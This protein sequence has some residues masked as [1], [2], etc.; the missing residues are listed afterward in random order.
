MPLDDTNWGAP[1][2]QVDETTAMLIRARGFLERGWCRG[3]HARDVA[4]DRVQP[5]SEKAVAWCMI[6]ALMAAGWE[7]HHTGHPAYQ[8]LA[9]ATNDEG[10]EFNDRQKTVEPILAAFD[11]AIG[12]GSGT[13]RSVP[14]GLAIAAGQEG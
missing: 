10:A 13:D 6:G 3:V 11:R 1:D 14:A 9:A 12:A 8:R 2:I 4:G 7:T 5:T